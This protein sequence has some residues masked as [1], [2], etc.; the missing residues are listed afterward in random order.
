MPPKKAP[1]NGLKRVPFSVR[2]DGAREVIL[3]GDFTGWA[4]DRLRLYKG[5]EGEWYTQ[6]EL[7][8]GQ[9]QYRLIVDGVWRD[10]PLPGPRVPNPFGTENSI[11]QVS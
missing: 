7:A 11:L 10:A 9:Y 4:T 3:T 2:L 8:P 1:R 5:P 6:L